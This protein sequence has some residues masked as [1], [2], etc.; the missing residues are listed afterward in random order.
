MPW[1]QK[2]LKLSAVSVLLGV[3][4]FAEVFTAPGNGL[5]PY[6]KP[7]AGLNS[8]TLIAPRGAKMLQKHGVRDFRPRHRSRAPKCLYFD[9][10]RALLLAPGRPRHAQFCANLLKNAP[11]LLKNAMVLARFA[12]QMLKLSA[13]ME[14]GAFCHKPLKT[15][16]I[17]KRCSAIRAFVSKR[18]VSWKW[19]MCR[20]LRKMRRDEVLYARKNHSI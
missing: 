20:D 11:D 17:F 10:G 8:S 7:H 15:L 1:N 6:P 4:H 16:T 12:K 18:K 2:R 19:L 3:E 13:R 14:R 9:R 5:S